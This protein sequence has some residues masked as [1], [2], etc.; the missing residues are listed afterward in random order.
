MFTIIHTLD[1]YHEVVGTEPALLIYFSTD[2]CSVCKVLKPKVGEMLTENFPKIKLFYVNLNQSPELA[3]QNRIFAVPTLQ[4]LFDGREYIR[5]SRN[6][7][8]DELKNE[9]E[10]PYQLMFS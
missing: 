8:L 5:K 6:F 1:Q 9:I 2:E 7:G 4:V 10:R 3:A